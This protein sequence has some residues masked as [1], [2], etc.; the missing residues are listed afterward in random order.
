VTD[1]I[2]HH[3]KIPRPVRDKFKAQLADIRDLR[4]Q[5]QV[6]DY[7]Q[8]VEDLFKQLD[9]PASTLHHA[10]TGL[11]G[12]GGEILDASKKTWVYNKKLDIEN[13]IE[14]LGDIRFYYQKILNMLN[15]SDEDIRDINTFKLKKR[16]PLGKYSDKHAQSRLDKAVPKPAQKK[17]SAS[18]VV[19]GPWV[20]KG[21]RK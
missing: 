16:Y 4:N 9:T 3:L 8:F 12:E 11:A 5:G 10:T 21:P 6:P 2:R 18:K 14:E 1:Q 13:L 15:L 17:K 7:P 20:T 19:Q